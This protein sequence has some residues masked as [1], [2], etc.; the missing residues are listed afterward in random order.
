M[1]RDTCK[2]PSILHFSRYFQ[3]TEQYWFDIS[4]KAE[5]E[6]QKYRTTKVIWVVD[7]LC[8][9]NKDFKDNKK[10][11]GLFSNNLSLRVEVDGLKSNFI[12]YDL[13]LIQ[14]LYSSWGKGQKEKQNENKVKT[15]RE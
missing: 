1:L 12:D 11:K 10:G 7:M 15:K 8:S 2:P 4:R 14:N 6:N 9:N 5:F 13:L 3:K